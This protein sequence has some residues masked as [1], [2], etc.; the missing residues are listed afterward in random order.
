M[1]VYTVYRW[2]RVWQFD[3]IQSATVASDFSKLAIRDPGTS[4]ISP[5]SQEGDHS[6]NKVQLVS[7]LTTINLAHT[8][9]CWLLT[10]GGGQTSKFYILTW[11]HYYTLNSLRLSGPYMSVNYTIT[12]SDNGLSRGWRQAIIWASAG[13]LSTGPLR[14]IFNKIFIEIYPFSFKKMHL[15]M[16]SRKWHPF[17]SWF[18]IVKYQAYRIIF[19]KI[20]NTK[21]STIYYFWCFC[22]VCVVLEWILMEH[23][24]CLF[25]SFR[26]A[27][28]AS[29]VPMPVNSVS[30]NLSHWPLG[31]L[32]IIL[33]V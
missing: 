31:D 20:N 16:S 8:N 1:P 6:N 2:Q 21:V 23:L 4:W 26:V 22:L 28:W 10:F 32:T 13:I 30:R 17:L 15:K 29:V 18:Q 3:A 9:H 5:A 14:T 19:Q 33:K 12:G 27:S 25:L 11:H 7:P 24:V